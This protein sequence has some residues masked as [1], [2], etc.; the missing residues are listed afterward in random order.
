MVNAKS[1]SL[2]LSA[3][4]QTQFRLCL[5]LTT[6]GQ[7]MKGI[8]MSVPSSE[9]AAIRQVI[10]ALI[11]VG[12]SLDSVDNGGGCV[13]VSTET[14]AIEEI[15]ATDSA[16]LFVESA[17]EYISGVWFVL[18]NSPEEVAA[19]WNVSIDHV[20]EPLLDKWMS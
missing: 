13:N 1:F 15:M 2:S 8:L 4:Y 19:D 7:V 17:K 12:Y 9:T 10:R 18:G 14:E 11:A 5:V 16:W 3:L 20:I 6:K